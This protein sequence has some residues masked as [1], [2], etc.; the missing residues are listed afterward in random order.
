MP[1]AVPCTVSC[2]AVL[3]ALAQSPSAR[4]DAPDA[5]DDAGDDGARE[6]QVPFRGSQLSF[7][8]SLYA[9]S[10]DQGSQLTYDPTYAWSFDLLL[11][12]HFSERT[13][14]SVEQ[15]LSLELTTQTDARSRQR[16]L[17]S[18]TDLRINQTL[19]AVSFSRARSFSL[20]GGVQAIAPTSLASQA[21]N[22]VV[23][24][25]PRLGATLALGDV[26]AGTRVR[27]VGGY[28]WR[29]SRA[30]T[31]GVDVPYPCVATDGALASCAHL[32]SASSP[33]DIVHAS[34]IAD[35]MLTQ[36]LG[37]LV[38]LRFD[39]WHAHALAPA[40]LTTDTGAVVALPD[41]SATHFRNART[42]RLGVSY[43]LSSWVQ[44]ELQLTNTFAERSPD[45]DLRGPLRPIDT[46][47]GLGAVFSLDGLYLAAAGEPQR[48]AQLAPR[49][50]ASAEALKVTAIKGP[51]TLITS[52]KSSIQ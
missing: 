3:C 23:S 12:W 18:D 24:A 40:I 7:E 10:L 35:A 51:I 1:R 47:F 29:F 31:T 25:G 36:E 19:W 22:V 15:A 49:A 37:M 28:L 39:F 52:P 41:R 16:A 42:L 21:A 9:N 20:L 48:T 33:R 4:A 43:A 8:Q 17:L 5:G 32:G 2:L 11:Y 34:L 30:T 46:V 6:A 13:Y 27:F 45:G 14:A 50:T 44:L 26:L 38:Q